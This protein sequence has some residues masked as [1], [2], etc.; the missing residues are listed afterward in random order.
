MGNISQ[1]PSASKVQFKLCILLLGFISS[2]VSF[3]DNYAP[4][5]TQIGISNTVLSAANWGSGTLLGVVDTGILPS[6]PSFAVNQVSASLSSCAALSFSCPKGSLDD[7]GHGTAVAEIAA[8]NTKFLYN[9]NYGGYAVS[10]NSYISVASNA[11]IFSEKVLN[12]QG[13]GYSTD[14]S[15]GIKKAA[16][17]GANVINVSITYGNSSDIVSS[18]NYAASKGSFI[19]WAGGNSAVSLMN[20][21]N[22]NG[23]TAN[24]ISHLIFAGS[25]NSNNVLSTFSNTPGKAA[26]VDVTGS[27]TSYASRWIMAPG[28]F[29]LAPYIKSSPSGWAYWSGTSMSTPIVS[30][31]L[32]LLE[33][34]WP[35]LKTNGTAANLLLATSTDLGAKGLDN[36][37]GNGL[38]N[39][40]NAFQ[41]YGTLS[42][43][44]ANG[45]LIPVPSITGSLISSGALG[46]M[47]SIQSKLSNLTAFDSYSRNYSVNLSGLIKVPSS[48]AITNPLPVNVNTGPKSVKFADGSEMSYWQPS[49]MSPS[50][51]LGMLGVNEGNSNSLQTGYVMLSTKDGASMAFG[52]GFPAQYS[53]AKSLYNNDDLSRL[54]SELEASNLTSLAQGG[55]LFSFGEKLDESTRLAFSFSGTAM[56]EFQTPMIASDASNL[57]FG[58]THKFTNEFTAGMTYGLLNERNGLLGSLY[59]N[60]SALSL[61]NMNQST[62]FGLSAGLN[63]DKNNSFLFEAA[64]A[65]TNSSSANGLFVG[66]SNVQSRSFGFSYMDKNLFIDS[67]RLIFSIKEPLRVSSGQ[68]GINS[69]TIDAQGNVQYATQWV[70][71]APEAREIDYKVSYEASLE[72]G[73]SISLQAGYRTDVLN[74]NGSNDANV[75]ANWVIHF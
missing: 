75:L 48:L 39:L 34:A 42:L 32:L 27:Q 51:K 44:G 58:I 28:E 73:N 20:G 47:S 31:S 41:P 8:G 61:G 54:S 36:V 70:N 12:S 62:S 1:N 33:S 66:T 35:I 23:L 25:V 71:L 5:L 68:V 69:P 64:V 55:R 21:S 19:V 53:Y 18:I 7:N 40:T 74:I 67:D 38:V 52:Y 2:N 9:S 46:S 43:T 30:G 56:P 22:T 49:P 15:N 11:N 50:E 60:N 29:I 24:A 13:S 3:A 14:V 59:G 72:S 63:L 26:L 65:Q 16:D 6:T 57:M 17:G 45:K 10:A 37:Y 4:W